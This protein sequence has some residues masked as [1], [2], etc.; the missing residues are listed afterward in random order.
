MYKSHRIL[1]HLKF[2][3]ISQISV[4]SLWHVCS[5]HTK[6]KNLGND[7]DLTKYLIND[8]SS[9]WIMRVSLWST[10]CV[11]L[12]LSPEKKLIIELMTPKLTQEGGEEGGGDLGSGAANLTKSYLLTFV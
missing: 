1:S 9:F 6:K 8:C 11:V 4:H 10:N 3:L 12:T 7:R 5:W 2:C